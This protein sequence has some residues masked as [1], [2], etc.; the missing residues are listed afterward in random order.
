MEAFSRWLRRRRLKKGTC[1]KGR[2]RHLTGRL[3]HTEACSKRGV[4][5]VRT[6][7]GEGTTGDLLCAVRGKPVVPALHRDRAPAARPAARGQGVNQSFSTLAC[8]GG[9]HPQVDRSAHHNSR[10]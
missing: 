3:L 4:H 9:F 1:S 8:F 6:L 7:Y 5:H 2:G 10:E